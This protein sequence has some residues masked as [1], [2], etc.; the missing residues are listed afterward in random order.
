MSSHVSYILCLPEFRQWTPLCQKICLRMQGQLRTRVSFLLVDLVSNVLLNLI[1][2]QMVWDLHHSNDWSLK[3]RFLRC[4]SK[5]RPTNIVYS[6]YN[7]VICHYKPFKAFSITRLKVAGALNN[8]C[9]YKSFVLFFSNFNRQN[10]NITPIY[11][12]KY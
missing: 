2:S 10:V 4:F 9:F 7:T 1:F 6:R 5:S 11:L 12:I 8:H 3:L